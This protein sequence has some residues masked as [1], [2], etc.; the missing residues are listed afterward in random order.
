[1]RE[2]VKFLQWQWRRFE[3]WQKLFILC[4]FLMGAGIAAEGLAQQ[5]L[6]G[7]AAVVYLGYIFKW[8]VWDGVRSSW[9]QYKQHRN[10]LFTTIKDSDR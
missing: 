9:Q 6:F 4:A 5:I 8:A 10:Q 7:T 2:I 1:M 3:L